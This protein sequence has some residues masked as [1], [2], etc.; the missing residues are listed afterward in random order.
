[1]TTVQGLVLTTGGQP[2]SGV[3]VVI[4]L[5]D[6]L[7]RHVLGWTGEQDLLGPV[8]VIT[9]QDGTWSAALTPSADVTSD[10]GDTL[11]QVRET[12]QGVTGQYFINV[13]TSVNPIWV[14]D[15]RAALSGV[16]SDHPLAAFVPLAG[17]E[18]TGTLVLNDGFPAASE[19]YVSQHGGGGG[20]AVSSVNGRTGAV[21]L[22]A[23]DVGA[24]VTGHSHSYEPAGTAASA[25]A[26]HAADTTSI[27]GIT[28]TSALETTTGSA[29]KVT[30]HE[31]AGDPHPGYLTASEGAAAY[32]PLSHGHAPRDVYPVSAY[33]LLAATG[34]PLNF[35]NNSSFA[36]GTLMLT[37]LFIPAGMAFSSVWVALRTAGSYDGTSTGNKVGIYTDAGALVDATTDDPTIWTSISP[38][39][40]RGGALAGGTQAAQGSDR[41]VYIAALARG[42]TGCVLPHPASAN[43]AQTVWFCRPVSGTVRRRAL[44]INGQSALPASF[45]PAASGSESTFALLAGVS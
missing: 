36:S 10:A 16:V 27:H 24:A 30:A 20:G 41:Y 43:D 3:Q 14:G 5:V 45:D 38:S 31:A 28:D 17:G 7:G 4:T 33:G 8:T 35:L 26:A 6:Q 25:V 15:V 29:A 11:Y 22:D 2:A 1:M 13:P 40:W 37:R 32:A 23:A 9:G 18:M 34:D 19:D 44:Y 21:V 12:Y 39:G 42:I